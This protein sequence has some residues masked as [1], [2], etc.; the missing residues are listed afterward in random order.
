MYQIK[1]K[2]KREETET[3][4]KGTMFMNKSV[5]KNCFSSQRLYN[6]R[7]AYSLS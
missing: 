4:I 2:G 1:V 5:H 7:Y 6:K 3:G